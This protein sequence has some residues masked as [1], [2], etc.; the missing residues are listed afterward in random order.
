[1]RDLLTS[2]AWSA[3]DLGM[4]LPDATHAVS[5]ALPQWQD[6]IDYEE[7]R[8]RVTSQMRAGYPRFFCH[9]RVSELFAEAEKRHAQA[10]EGALVFPSSAAAQRAIAYITARAPEAAA[11]V[12]SFGF[13]SL[14]VVLFAESARR[15]AREYWRYGGEIVS[16]RLAACALDRSQPDAPPRGAERLVRERLA[17]LYG[18]PSHHVFLFVSGMAAV[19]ATHR[20]AIAQRPGRRSAQVDFPYVD[21][22]K[23]QEECGT[24]AVFLGRADGDDLKSL[25]ALA[26]ADALAAVFCETPSNPLLRTAPLAEMA[27]MLR[28]AGVPLIVDDTVASVVNVEALRYADVVTSSLTKVFSGTGDVMAGAVVVSPQSALAPTF[29]AALERDVAESGGLWGE[30]AAVLERNSRDVVARVHR[31]NATAANL[32]AWLRAQP[33][34]TTVHYPDDDA[35]RALQRP[36]AG[37]GALFS[38]I[39]KDPASA[40]TFF[41]ALRVSKGPSLGTNF[42]LACPYTLLAHYTELDWAAQCGVPAHLIRVSVGL[43]AESDLISRFAAALSALAVK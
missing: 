33:Q 11:R 1:M 43:E 37:Q 15:W 16:S 12:V 36:G 34:I 13:H 38:V 39:L 7:N 40:P 27:P 41:D 6:V 5:V 28:D 9:P 17:G 2:P 26:A 21:V 35:F 22:L 8:P 3:A 20:C 25:A 4:P 19:A 24:G 42:T 18:V 29:C 14:Q 31:T 10:G 23:V 32:V 30:D